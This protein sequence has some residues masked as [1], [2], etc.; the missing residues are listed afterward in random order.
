[1]SFTETSTETL[2]GQPVG[3]GTVYRH[4]TAQGGSRRILPKWWT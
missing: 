1:M 3:V 4:V 2:D